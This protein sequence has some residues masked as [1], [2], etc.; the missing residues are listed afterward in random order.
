MDYIVIKHSSS[1]ELYHHGIL[2]MKWGI[3]RTPAQLGHPT[4]TP[5]RTADGKIG[6]YNTKGHVTNSDYGVTKSKLAKS[7]VSKA[8]S[9][10]EHSMTAAKEYVDNK[11]DAIKRVDKYL[12]AD[13]EFA[14]IQ[15]SKDVTPY[16]FYATYKNKDIEKYAGLFGAN[17]HRRADAAAKEAEKKAKRNREDESLQE[18]AKAKREYVDHMKVYQVRFSAN[19]KLKVPSDRNAEDIVADLYKDNNFRKDLRS[20][21]KDT[22]SQMRRPN[23]Q[24]LLSDAERIIRKQSSDLTRKER[25]T[26]YK[27][28]NLSLTFHDKEYFNNTSNQ[29]YDALKKKGYSAIVD[30]NDQKYSSYHAKKPMI[31][32]DT[33]SVSIKSIKSLDQHYMDKLY[34]KYNRERIIKEIPYQI[35]T[36]LPNYGKTLLNDAYEYKYNKTL[37]YLNEDR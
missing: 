9:A 22:K 2:G 21:I 15:V 33:D 26:L 31:V 34:T 1:S 18:D 35:A 14:R 5:R 19:K 16:A 17:L 11:Y 4:P 20:A 12:D 24:A 27:A 37:D 23:Q 30:I 10:M 25:S 29:F 6:T 13:V 36:A 32:F 3:R 28:L 7:S 8:V